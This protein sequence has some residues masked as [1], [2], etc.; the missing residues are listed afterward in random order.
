MPKLTNSIQHLLQTHLVGTYKSLI[1]FHS[2]RPRFSFTAQI[3]FTHIYTTMKTSILALAAVSFLQLAIAEPHGK[4]F[5]SL[6]NPRK[7]SHY[8]LGHRHRKRGLFAQREVVTDV[9]IVTAPEVVVYVDLQG[10]TLSAWT[11][12]PGI[13]AATPTSSAVSSPSIA[14]TSV[15]LS[16]AQ[17]QTPAAT[18]IVASSSAPAIAAPPTHT[19]SDAPA[20]SAPAPTNIHEKASP[21]PATTSAPHA[22]EAADA[23][24]AI[25]ASSD[26]DNTRAGGFAGLGITYSAYNADSSCKSEDQI[27]NELAALTSYGTIR[28]YGSDCNQLAVIGSFAAAHGMKVFAGVFDIGN[29]IGELTRMQSQLNNHWDVVT[30][31]SI[32]NEVV[33]NNESQLGAVLAAL[34][35]ARSFLDGAGYKGQIITVD[36]FVA[37][38]SHPE[39]CANSDFCAANCH[40]FFNAD[41][42]ADQAGDYVS[43]IIGQISSKVAAGKKVVITESGWP[44]AGASN[45]AAVPS[46]TNQK[47]ALA[48]LNHALGGQFIAFAAYDEAWKQSG[49]FGVEQFWGI[50]GH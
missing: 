38:L 15:P 47:T 50:Y 2:Q 11:E 29:T 18:P 24:P 39:L 3:I 28:I 4:P 30:T 13:A 5:R 48:S 1:K 36:T 43:T 41:T 37:H 21:A 42:T 46:D 32:G 10:N 14:P 6:E 35:A 33:Q 23:A 49:Q 22:P 20:A 16:T 25:A 26:G 19:T 31:I 8:H 34:S 7:Y 12:S 9:Q 44:H 45:G 27:N 17:T 40:A